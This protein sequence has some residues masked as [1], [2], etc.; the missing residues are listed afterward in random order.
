MRIYTLALILFAF[1]VNADS[2]NA[3]E[4][5][6][7]VSPDGRYL[8]RVEP[9]WSQNKNAAYASAHAFMWDGKS[10]K[11]IRKFALRNYIAPSYIL[12]TNNSTLF[13]FD[14]H[15]ELGGDNA[16]VV[17]SLFGTVIKSYELNDLFPNEKIDK[18]H[19][20]VSSIWWRDTKSPPWTYS[21]VVCVRDS[22]GGSFRINTL[23]GEY[24]YS[25][26]Q[27]CKLAL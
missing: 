12:V 5:K 3:P 8:V 9:N 21:D 2:W 14:D 16:I 26:E 25:N 7:S 24:E 6:S 15:G 13:A 1:G 11:L 17:Y 22:S 19:T 20:T 18:F 4:T 10:Y 27:G 23:T